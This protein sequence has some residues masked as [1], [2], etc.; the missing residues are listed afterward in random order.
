[1]CIFIQK[2]TIQVLV[3]YIDINIHYEVKSPVI[4]QIA[5]YEVEYNKFLFKFSNTRI[6]KDER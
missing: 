1:M 4:L 5:D 2:K 3:M 6:I